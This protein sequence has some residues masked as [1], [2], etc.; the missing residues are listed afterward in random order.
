MF[1]RYNVRHCNRNYQ[2]IISTAEANENINSWPLCGHKP[3]YW[4]HYD[5]DLVMA[6]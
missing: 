4:T 3:N 2:K 6:V 1:S 5:D